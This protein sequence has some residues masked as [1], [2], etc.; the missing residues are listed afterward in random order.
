MG[1]RLRTFRVSDFWEDEPHEAGSV[2]ALHAVESSVGEEVPPV[3]AGLGEEVHAPQGVGVVGEDEVHAEHRVVDVHDAYLADL[4]RRIVD[5][6]D[7]LRFEREGGLRQ[8]AFQL[9]PSCGQH[10]SVVVEG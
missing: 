10:G 8:G 1:L 6:Q 9:F 4:L 7:V 5:P 2:L 3:P